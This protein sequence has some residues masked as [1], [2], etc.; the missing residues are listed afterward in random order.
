MPYGV[1]WQDRHR[2]SPAAFVARRCHCVGLARDGCQRPS[3]QG[4]LTRARFAA[5]AQRKRRDGAP[6][7]GLG[8]RRCVGADRGGRIV[9]PSPSLRACVRRR[10]R[11]IA[12]A[13]QTE[14]GDMRIASS[15]RL[16]QFC[17]KL[18]RGAIIRKKQTMRKLKFIAVIL[19]APMVG[20]AAHAQDNSDKVAPNNGPTQGHPT[21]QDYVTTTGATVPRPETL[22]QSSG[23]TALDRKMRERSKRIMNSICSGC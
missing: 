2:A 12:R 14:A 17:R 1:R 4:N 21:T 20:I 6:A 3:V 19:A 13:Q 15:P 10:K 9:A 22:P 23:E 7:P 16:R 8:R 11:K 5:E 18:G